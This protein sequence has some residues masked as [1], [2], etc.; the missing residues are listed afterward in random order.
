MAFLA[1][2]PVQ[3]YLTFR[4]IDVTF[5]LALLNI[6]YHIETLL[7]CRYTVKSKNLYEYQF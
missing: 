1:F 6:E 5:T 7:F 4:S 3:V 2:F